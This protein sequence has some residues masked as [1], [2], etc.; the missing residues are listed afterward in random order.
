M[1]LS[2]AY[3][4]AGQ[5]RNDGS[6]IFTR[7][8]V[9][10]PSAS[11]QCHTGPRHASTTDNAWPPAGSGGSEARVA[12]PNR[13]AHGHSRGTVP[14]H[15]LDA[16]RRGPRRRRGRRVLRGEVREDST[17]A[18]SY[19]AVSG[20]LRPA[21]RGCQV[22]DFLTSIARV[23]TGCSVNSN[24]A[25]VARGEYSVLKSHEPLADV[26]PPAGGDLAADGGDPAGRHGRVPAA[27]GL[28]AAPGR[29]SDH[30]GAHVLSRREPG[31][32]GVGGD[33]AARAAVRPAARPQPDDVHQL[34]GGLAGHAAVQS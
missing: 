2:T 11:T 31:R 21:P 20:T 8:S 18:S 29:L 5:F 15:Q 30:P 10:G 17:T 23:K 24:L 4:S 14:R 22:P 34:V 13:R 28:R 27:A 33:D 32:D 9:S 16:P 1:L 26:H 19:P 3:S 12:P 7:R 6:T 25:W